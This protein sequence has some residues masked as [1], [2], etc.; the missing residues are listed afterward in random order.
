MRRI[1]KM[2]KVWRF[3]ILLFLMMA[4]SGVTSARHQ[5][6][7]HD[8]NVGLS[9]VRLHDSDNIIQKYGPIIPGHDPEE[10]SDI[11]V[12]VAPAFQNLPESDE[13]HHILPYIET[14]LREGLPYT[15]EPWLG[16]N[17][18]FHPFPRMSEWIVDWDQG[19]SDWRVGTILP[20]DVSID[21]VPE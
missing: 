8:L 6:Q 16:A 19:L 21:D 7:H 15:R 10:L 9:D 4:I 11:I 2:S 12:E 5:Q 14:A 1:W 20:E 17:Y 13:M 3:V 18:D